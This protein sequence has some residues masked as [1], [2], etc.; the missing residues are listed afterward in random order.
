M[1]C[2]S[3]EEIGCS[4]LSDRRRIT[5]AANDFEQVIQNLF[6]VSSPS[7]AG[8]LRLLPVLW[9]DGLTICTGLQW[10]EASA[11]VSASA[12]RG[13]PPRDAAAAGVGERSGQQR[14]ARAP[15][16]ALRNVSQLLACADQLHSDTDLLPAYNRLTSSRVRSCN[17][18][19]FV[20]KLIRCFTYLLVL[21]ILS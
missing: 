11:L 9:L 18:R 3:T 15:K 6:Y 16:L 8:L 4:V 1:R 17:V 10:T 20:N 7:A 5:S 19:C 13:E 2:S 14:Q 12:Q 21:F